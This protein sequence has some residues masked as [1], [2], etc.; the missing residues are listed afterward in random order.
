MPQVQEAS[1]SSSLCQSHSPAISGRVLSIFGLAFLQ[2]FAL[3]QK[4]Q[5]V[6]FCQVFSRFSF[7]IV[8]NWFKC[9]FSPFNM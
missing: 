5:N 9:S 3:I 1:D 6:I 2:K 7:Y 4:H 8:E